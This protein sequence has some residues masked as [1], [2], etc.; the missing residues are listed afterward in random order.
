MS[1][2]INYN[3]NVTV[4]VSYRRISMNVIAL[5]LNETEYDVNSECSFFKIKFV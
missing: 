2:R 1:C 5:Q 3:T 4:T